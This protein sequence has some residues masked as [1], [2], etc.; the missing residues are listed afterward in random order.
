MDANLVIEEKSPIRV[1]VVGGG[2]GGTLVANLIGRR[3]GERAAV[4]LVTAS[5]WHV[6]EPGLLYVP[7][8]DLQQ[9]DVQRPI[10][11]LLRPEVSLVEEPAVAI[12][13]A[14]KRLRMRSG[15]DLS[16]DYLVLATGTEFAAERLPGSAQGAHHFFTVEAAEKL[17][18]ALFRFT[19]GRI[20]VAAAELPH[21]HPQALLE[22]AFLL[23]DYCER[24]G[25]AGR[26]EIVFSS[27]ADRCFWEPALARI[28]EKRFEERGIRFEPRLSPAAVLPDA[29]LLVARGGREIPYDLLVMAPPQR[30]VELVRRSGLGNTDGWLPT[31]PETLRL[32]GV[33]DVWVLGDCSDLAVSRAPSAADHQARV[34]AEAIAADYEGRL[35]RRSLAVYDGSVQFFVE[36]GDGQ[37]AFLDADYEH[38]ASVQEPSKAIAAGRRA[39]D[40]AYWQLIPTGLA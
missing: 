11:D 16:W 30:G 6:Y 21:K 35:P 8:D 22:F 13:V 40:R 19:G 9:V 5:P 18:D 2:V 1:A 24:N 29:K 10:R 34:V 36:M 20:V 25:L 12:D 28:A 27:P 4:E 39:F 17:H 14:G 15:L 38:P 32:R 26:T 33:R 31:D 37:A 3:L 23:S 7:F